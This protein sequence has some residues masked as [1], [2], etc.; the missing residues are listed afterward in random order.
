[1]NHSILNDLSDMIGMDKYIQY[2]NK[3][4]DNLNKIFILS[5][6]GNTGTGKSSLAY[7][8]LKNKN[9][10]IIEF[11]ISSIKSKQ[12]IFDK[13]KESFKTYDICSM[14][15][16]KKQKTAY[17][18]D[19]MNNQSMSKSELNELHSI[20]IKNN[21][22]R[23]VILVGTYNK[24]TNYPKKKIDTLKIYNPHETIL[25][26]ISTQ[27]NK[28]L[29]YNISI[30]NLKLIVSKCQ[31]DIKK[32]TILL[33]YF[34]K[35]QKI[36]LNQII[37]KNCSYNLFTDFGNLMN[38]YKDIE[39]TNIFS[40]QTILLTY[41]FHQNIYNF[42]I[43]NCKNNVEDHLFDW[44][45]RLIECI[46]YS[47]YMDKTQNWDFLNYIYY[48]GP[49]YISYN[50]NKVKK[51]KNIYK[52]IDYP[53]YCYLSNQKNLYKKI[54]Q[55]FKTFDFYEVLNEN[56]FKIFIKNLF[57]NKI[58]N[59]HIFDKLSKDDIENLHKIL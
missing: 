43:N 26:K 27:I 55:I 48:V 12:S 58:K 13:I 7:L 46:D 53:K 44:N 59:Q 34:K 11:D 40:D 56:N 6:E 28:K 39:S 9:Y 19:N 38:N 52:Q 17:I 2:M 10:N 3:W 31:Q 24:S 29:N 18:I 50:Y 16:N 51:N 33:E 49:K 54:I 23:P 20:F 41:T 8:F 57:D 30:L 15:N 22:V 42:S 36:D 35:N 4:Y 32:L 14:F 21:T 25:L 5:I 1:M 45:N 47:Q 37:T